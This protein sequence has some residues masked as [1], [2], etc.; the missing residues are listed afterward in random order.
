MDIEIFCLCDYAQEMGSGK[1]VIIGTFDTI[2][3]QKMP[4]KHP[5][6]SIVTRIRFTSTEVGRHNFQV[7]ILDSEGS[8][9]VPSF[10]AEFDVQI[11]SGIESSLANFVMGIGGLEFK[12]YGT[13]S[14]TLMLDGTRA[15]SLPLY[16]RPTK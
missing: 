2:F 5:T 8:D 13:Y 10:H 15:K 14:I 3:A 11:A 12:K 1:I 4:S 6:C 9:I 16:V 7:A